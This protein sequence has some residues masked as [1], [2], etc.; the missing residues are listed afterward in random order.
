MVWLL[1]GN[2]DEGGSGSEIIMFG[3]E[4]T[5]KTTLSLAKPHPEAWDDSILLVFH[6]F[7]LYELS[8]C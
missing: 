4:L 2:E 7:H 5:S 8:L 1:V 3:G 6:T